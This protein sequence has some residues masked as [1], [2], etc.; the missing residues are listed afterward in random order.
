MSAE[1]TRRVTGDEG[2]SM[3]EAVVVLTDGRASVVR[4][5][6]GDVRATRA[7][8]CLLEPAPRDKVL[9]SSSRTGTFVLAILVREASGPVRVV[10]EESIELV[11]RKGTVLL[12]AADDVSV[13]GGRAFTVATPEVAVHAEQGNIRVDRLSF[14]GK[15][16][17][18]SLGALKV[19][20]ETIDRTA[21]RAMERL[22]RSYRFVS[23]AEHVRASELDIQTESTLSL[24]AENA[25]VIAR[26]V[27][28]MDGTQI[29]MG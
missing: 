21:E 11:S 5:S 4:T 25:V 7:A 18:V 10:A 17:D 1:A 8:S 14:L 28:K 9:I 27:V 29:H 22:G 24:R 6:G 13:V 16:A 3:E 23:E 12:A 15:I 26:K 2:C 19:V 20:A